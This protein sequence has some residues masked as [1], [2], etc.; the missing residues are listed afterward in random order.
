MHVRLRSG[1]KVSGGVENKLS[2]RPRRILPTIADPL[3]SEPTRDIAPFFV[4]MM[5]TVGYGRD[6]IDMQHIA[7]LHEIW[8][9]RAD[10]FDLSIASTS[11]LKTVAGYCLAAGFSE[12][13]LRAGKISAARDAY[14]MG[15][16]PRVYSPQEMTSQLVET[17]KA[18]MPDDIDG[19]DAEY[20]D[21]L[22]GRTL[23]V[24]YRLSGDYGR[25]VE[26]IKVPGVTG[27]TQ[28]WRMAAR[29]RR[30]GA[31]RRTA[32]KGGTELAAMNSYYLDYVGLQDGI[33]EWGQSAFV[34][35]AEDNTL[36]LSESVLSAGEPIYA[37]LRRSDGT[38]TAP[39]LV[40]VTNGPAITLEQIPQDVSISTE[41]G[42]STVVYIG[43]LTQIVHEALITEVRPSSDGRVEFQAIAMD[44]RVYAEDDNYGN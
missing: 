22:T 12:L 44:N 34:L 35:S 28:A 21:Y 36:V 25:R 43:K 27:R 14:R 33:P 8:K 38:A 30:V 5:E 23:T 9:A 11:T 15:S 2:I 42:R 10:V 40:T 4:Y 19:V 17:T 39:I 37:M 18:I 13:T 1:Y 41:P 6:L 29:Q 31:Y 26:T 32:F 16:P 24:P 20:I 7:A 3:V